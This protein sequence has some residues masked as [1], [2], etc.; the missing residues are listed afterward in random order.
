MDEHMVLEIGRCFQRARALKQAWTA[1]RENILAHQQFAADARI[2]SAPIAY[3]NVD[4][5][6]YEVGETIRRRQSHIDVF[7]RLAEFEEARDQPFGGEGIERA[8]IDDT[9]RL[10]IGDGRRG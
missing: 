6:A 4:A 7:L 5:V 10:T 2:L 8:D 3:R 9:A 1:D